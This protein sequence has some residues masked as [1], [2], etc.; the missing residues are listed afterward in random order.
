MGIAFFPYRIYATIELKKFG[1]PPHCSTLVRRTVCASL[2]PK[3]QVPNFS[4]FEKK[5]SDPFRSV[6]QRL[7]ELGRL[8][9]FSLE[10]YLYLLSKSSPPSS[11]ALLRLCG[12]I[13]PSFTQDVNCIFAIMRFYFVLLQIRVA[14]LLHA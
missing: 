14:F 8:L 5:Y 9:R 10:A 11:I 1:L 7:L 12:F 13:V 6:L 3:N 4:S 2:R